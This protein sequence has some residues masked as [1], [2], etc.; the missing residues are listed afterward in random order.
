M[1][2]AHFVSANGGLL[3]EDEYPTICVPVLTTPCRTRKSPTK[4]YMLTSGTSSL[5]SNGN[6]N[7]NNNNEDHSLLILD[8]TYNKADAMTMTDSFTSSSLANELAELQLTLSR[9]LFRLSNIKDSGEKIRFYTGFSNYSSLKTVYDFLGPSVNS[10]NYWG[11]E[12]VGDSKSSQG[13]NRS[14][15]PMEEFFLVLVRIRL[16]LFENDLAYRFDV[17]VS[18]VCRI[19]ITWINFMY[20]RLKSLPLWPKREVVQSYMPAVFK[21][22]YPTTCVIIDAT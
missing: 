10:L 2:S 3:R 6:D 13:R 4:R 18:T 12:I 5:R 21:D 15:P 22:L 20:V 9:N 11:S 19:C 1:C 14:L 8:S 7:N 16:G 17:S